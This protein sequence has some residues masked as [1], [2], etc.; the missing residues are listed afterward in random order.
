MVT[1]RRCCDLPPFWLVLF[2]ACDSEPIFE[3]LSTGFFGLCSCAFWFDCSCDIVSLPYLGFLTRRLEMMLKAPC[4]LRVSL[5]FEQF[6][7]SCS[8]QLVPD[9][10]LTDLGLDVIVSLSHWPVKALLKI[11]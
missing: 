4:G 11:V 7:F 8:G 6:R 5:V 1:P 2:P 10:L 9:F 3:A